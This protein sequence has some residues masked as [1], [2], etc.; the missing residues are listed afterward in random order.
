MGDELKQKM[1]KA[2]TWTS[3]DRFGQQ[4]IQFVIGLI[5]ARLL[6]PEEFGLI[7]LVTIFVA[8]SYVLIESGFTQALIRKKDADKSYFSTIY[9]FNILISLTLY[10]ILFFL[11]PLIAGFFH[12]ESLIAISR[13]IFLVIIFNAFC[14]VPSTILTKE[15]NFKALARINIVSMILSGTTGLILAWMGYGVWS[16]VAQQTLFAFFRMLNF[17]FQV[18]WKAKRVFKPAIIREFAPFSLNL[19]GTSLL[20][21]T[22]N[23]IFIFILGLFYPLKQVGYYTQGNKLS[24]TFN[25]S[26]QS[27]ISASTYPLFA[28]I[29]D[30]HERLRRIF[31]EITRKVSI[32]TFPVL[33]FM[34]VIAKPFIF[35]L[36]TEKFISS[37]PYFQLLVA[38]SLFTPMYL[39]NINLLNA[40]GKSGITFKIEII[41]K[42]LILIAILTGFKWGIMTM[43]WEYAVACTISYGVSAIYLKREITHYFRHQLQDFIISIFVAMIIAGSAYLLSL[44]IHQQLLLLFSQSFIALFLYI[45]LIYVYYRS[46]YKEIIL[47]I[48]K[49]VNKIKK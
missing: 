47:F 6:N 13:T 2:L 7:G 24:E 38:A 39:M 49:K 33:I 32:I 43:L 35:V 31:R 16:L 40:R 28:K 34:I 36:L 23:N 41:K 46:F 12:Q 21:V 20:N 9:F 37:V 26:F 8:I 19:L 10:L 11:A 17:T 30:E 29:L 1:V 18:K 4:I 3:I 22:F 44:I 14:L 15:L 48:S 5:L 27:I 25:F 42:I 45:I